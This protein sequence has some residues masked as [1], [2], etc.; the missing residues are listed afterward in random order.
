M[1]VWTRPGQREQVGETAPDSKTEGA[2]KKASHI[3]TRHANTF[4]QE[5]AAA[6][7]KYTGWG[8]EKQTGAGR[9]GRRRSPSTARCVEPQLML[10]SGETRHIAATNA[11]LRN[12]P[13][14]AP[15]E[16]V[17]NAP[18]PGPGPVNIPV[19]TARLE[20]RRRRLR[21]FAVEISRAGK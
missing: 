5:A 16:C 15:P 2:T 12:F 8:E 14:S 20:S 21:R 13:L 11:P 10:E 17:A 3:S 18:R 4:P 1:N 6:Q 9:S 7:R 19:V